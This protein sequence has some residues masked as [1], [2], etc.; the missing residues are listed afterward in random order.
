MATKKQS[1]KTN[2]PTYLPGGSETSGA[3]IP[4]KN[5]I[6]PAE[7]FKGIVI[8]LS[9]TESNMSTENKYAQEA[10]NFRK[11]VETAGLVEANRIRELV[12]SEYLPE[13][14]TDEQLTAT[15][16]LY[17]LGVTSE[18]LEEKI[19]A[20]LVNLSAF[21]ETEKQSLYAL[22]YLIATFEDFD[23]QQT[24]AIQFTYTPEVEIDFSNT[25][26]T[27]NQFMIT[28]NGNSFQPMMEGALGKVKEKV[29]G[30]A[31]DEVTDFA[32]NA[33]GTGGKKIA[34][35]GKGKAGRTITRKLSELF[36]KG[37]KAGVKIAETGTDVAIASTGIGALAVIGKKALGWMAK[38]LIP[39]E[40]REWINRNKGKLVVGAMGTVFAMFSALVLEILATI[41][42][43]IGG[44]T[45]F[46]IVFT[47][48]TLLI[49]N[50]SAYLVPFNPDA[51]T[52]YATKSAYI[53]IS[54]IAN[55]SQ[56]E[57]PTHSSPR[58]VEYTI[59]ITAR[60]GAISNVQF[61]PNCQVVGGTTSTCPPEENITVSY[62]SI[63]G[64]VCDEGHYCFPAE[65]NVNGD[66]MG[67]L[68]TPATPCSSGE[69]CATLCPDPNTVPEPITI[70]PPPVPGVITPSVPYV[71]TYSQ[72]FDQNY[73]DSI[74]MDTFTV[75]A[76]TSGG[77]DTVADSAS[78]II[79]EVLLDCPLASYNNYGGQWGSYSPGI[80]TQGHGSNA[81]WS[82]FTPCDWSIPQGINCMGPTD[83]MASN[84]ICY[85]QSSKCDQY[86]YAYD[87][88]PIGSMDVFAPQILG[89][90]HTWNCSYAF[91]NGSM[92]HSYICTSDQYT[93]VL[94]HMNELLSNGSRSGTFV[95]GQ[96][97]GTLFPMGSNTHLHI[98]FAINGVYQTPESFFCL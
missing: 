5:I 26:P 83:P 1:Q 51:I 91:S 61:Q 96:R 22:P 28:S 74:V 42:M 86:G 27:E 88:A 9:T 24:T 35:E 20:L 73:S 62:P 98:E 36:K 77:S 60:Q 18:K 50:N 46:V 2:T 82:S 78:V 41:V 15:L 16:H 7:K 37:V 89:N 45:L 56:I 31:K 92:G 85:N 69:I 23:P 68:D 79:G 63:N 65:W 47:V 38:H 40:L 21:S 57:N 97:V 84:N 25:P 53:Q 4:S 66:C 29:T 33:I 75:T 12:S 34:K 64:E 94:T 11:L 67:I 54:K 58:T 14:F 90:S 95:S 32:S 71:I 48:L 49:I 19:D 72:T 17:S 76:S 87:M 43:V 80:E 8:T 39:K 3:V 30:T 6:A 44:F 93:L 52:P 55:P 81:Y 13:S 10:V 70:F 59:T